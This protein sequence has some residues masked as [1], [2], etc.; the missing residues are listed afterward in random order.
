MLIVRANSIKSEAF[1]TVPGVSKGEL[2]LE[3]CDW[4]R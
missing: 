1:L 2:T 4:E 3:V